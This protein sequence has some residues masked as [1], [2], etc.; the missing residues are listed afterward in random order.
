[1]GIDFLRR[2]N[3][4]IILSHGCKEK[5][6]CSIG[7]LEMGQAHFYH[8]VYFSPALYRYIKMDIPSDYNYAIK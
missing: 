1:M 3:Q 8:P 6:I 4:M 2:Q 7:D 5:E